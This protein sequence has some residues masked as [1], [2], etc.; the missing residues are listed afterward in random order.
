MD[1]ILVTDVYER[2]RPH[3]GFDHVEII[4]P[5]NGKTKISVEDI[6][7][8][9][10]DTTKS[11]V[12][13]IDVRMTTMARLRN[14]YNK[15]V[16]YN[17]A[18]FNMSCYTVLIGQGPVGFLHSSSS[19]EAFKPYLADM[20]ID[21]S[22]AVFFSDPFLHY[23]FMEMEQTQHNNQL[24]PKAVP[25]HLEDIFKERTPTV[26]QVRRYFRAADMPESMRE[27]KKKHRLKK[28]AEAL[29]KKMEKQFPAEKEVFRKG[30]SKKGCPLPG[31]ALK[32][33]IYPF[34]FEEWMV[35]LIKGPK[36][37]RLSI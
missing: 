13:I 34:F 11:R 22:P 30:L 32:L 3:H 17:R 12:V 2:L 26:E 31:E 23:T 1:R 35:D 18:D 20:R 8:L 36:Q 37:Y 7:R 9:A 5:G 19:L 27:A 10:L 15:V 33:N 29:D 24:F 21:Y 25:H 14:A 16:G 4:V 6:D 28:L